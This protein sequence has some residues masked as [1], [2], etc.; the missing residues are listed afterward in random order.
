MMLT[1]LLGIG[2]LFEQKAQV[3]HTERA[4][5]PAG[6]VLR[7]NG[8]SGELTIEG[9]DRPDVEI[10]TVATTKLEYAEKDREQAK[11][12]LGQVH[13][14]VNRQGESVAITPDYPRHMGLTA[15]AIDVEYYIKAPMNARLEVDHKSGEVHVENLT[16]DIHVT[17][18]QGEIT[19]LLPQEGHYSIDAKC[20]FGDVTS[21]FPGQGK[22]RPWLLGHEFDQETQPGLKLY[23][24]VGFGDILVLKDQKP[25]TPDPPKE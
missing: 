12:E 4:D 14:T 16:S 25:A 13:V 21:D 2:L 6:G 20:R 3:V 10:T 7:I 17:V 11:S 24:R 19:L 5:F 15:G 23:L 22:R 1:V 8:S 18:R 9:W